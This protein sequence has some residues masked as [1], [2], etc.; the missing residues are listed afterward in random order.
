[1]HEHAASRSL[2]LS[3]DRTCDHHDP[4]SLDPPGHT[5]RL[6]LDDATAFLTMSLKLKLNTARPSVSDGN[7]PAERAPS[8]PPPTPGSTTS[9]GGIR[10][11]IKN[12][13]PPTPTSELPPPIP[14]AAPAPK[15]KKAAT[16]PA[17]SRKST[18]GGSK[19]RV[20]NDDTISPAAK[21]LAGPSRKISIKIGP[22]TLA[23]L[24]KAPQSAKLTLKT[25]R[26]PTG[27][28]LK[29]LN[30][31][32]PPPPRL[33]GQGYD[34]EDSEAEEDPSM[35][36]AFVLRMQPGEDCDYLHDAIAN[37]RVG[38]SLAEGGAEVSFRFIEK[39]NRR[40]VVTVRKT[41]YA[42]AL[43]DLPC[44]V[45]TMK[46]WD[47][48][49]WWKV[50]DM[51]QMLLVLGRCNSDEEA[52][53]Y[54]LPRE[55]DSSNMQYAHGLTP[56]MHWV[57]K[58]RFRKRLSY[59]TIANVD[60]EVER[61][62]HEDELAERHGGSVRHDVIDPNRRDRITESVGPE[63]DDYDD[64]Q[65]ALETIENGQ[66]EEFMEDEDGLD[67]EG[68]LQ[69]MFDEEIAAS[70]PTA[71]ATEVVSDSPAPIVDQI[72]PLQAL[73]A[74]PESVAGTPVGQAIIAQT[75][76]D[77]EEDDDAD[78]GS[79]SSGSDDDDEEDEDSPTAMDEDAAAKAA[80]RNQQLEEVADLEREI[81]N[82]RYKCDNM[83]NALLKQRALGQLRILEEDLR[84]KKGVF[85]LEDD[86]DEDADAV[87]AAT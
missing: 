41:M 59:K 46:S 72:I 52:R 15:A 66:Q 81:A 29:G 20:A 2:S 82:Q 83:T 11:S 48:K 70:T 25:Q 12:S 33:P 56:P 39:D 14:A 87:E 77:P 36:Q 31:R 10:L 53:A 47:R 18:G 22:Q 68:D 26:K 55:V 8:I 21:R 50:A 61:L 80:E 84:V 62:L 60:E 58:R 23:S 16:Q 44:I 5:D 49:G 54:P 71:I 67:L 79:E 4:L 7:A 27:P 1:M 65:D 19:K 73:T 45:E 34:S 37:G 38:L 86:D 24:E 32:K 51:S 69:A 40:A 6:P 3:K 57:R 9:T 35:Q 13:V 85:G 30:A 42:A 28:K 78:D 43:V 74:D 76:D 64:G 17:K 63:E 75:S